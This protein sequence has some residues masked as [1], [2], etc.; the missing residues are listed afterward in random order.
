MN[1]ISSTL[2]CQMVIEE[3]KKNGL[4]VF[5]FGLGANPLKPNSTYIEC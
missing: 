3:R 4:E 5:N 1:K 2:R